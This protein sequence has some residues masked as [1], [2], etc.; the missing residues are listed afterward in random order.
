MLTL[1][2]RFLQCS[3]GLDGL[4][5]RELTRQHFYGFVSTRTNRHLFEQKALNNKRNCDARSGGAANFETV[6][7]ANIYRRL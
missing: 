2:L 6:L 1:R 4:R 3:P 5:C 7:A